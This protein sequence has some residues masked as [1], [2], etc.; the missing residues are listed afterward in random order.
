MHPLQKRRVWSR[1]GLALESA[2]RMRM[3]SLA[4]SLRLFEAFLLDS[5]LGL[6]KSFGFCVSVASGDR[7]LFL[8]PS[9]G[10]PFLPS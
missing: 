6:S 7:V 10:P 9:H 8:R 3:C 1:R 5:V 4:I 2:A